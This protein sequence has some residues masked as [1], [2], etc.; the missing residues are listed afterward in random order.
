MTTSRRPL[1]VAFALLAGVAATSL[2][3]CNAGPEDE[4]PPPVEEVRNHRYG[5]VNAVIETTLDRAALTDAQLDVV[6]AIQDEVTAHR[7]ERK[8]L[9]EEMRTAASAIVREG[10]TDSAEFDAMV[11]RAAVAIEKRVEMSADAVKD[12]HELLEPEQRA[13]VAEGLRER[14]DRRWGN[15]H[16]R[17]HEAFDTFA[18]ELA[19]TDDQ[20]RG[21]EKVRDEMLGQ[22]KRLKPTAEELYDLVDAFET[23]DFAAALD[24]FHAERAPLLR[25]KLAT[26]GDHADTILGLLEDGQ[27]DILAQLI[28]EG[29][30]S[31]AERR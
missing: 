9:R 19:L 11:E 17:R 10:T 16:R 21:I 23:E 8:Q 12:L 14:I 4:P 24:A 26:A 13:A 3:A 15:V 5:A 6:L 30:G 31:L 27:R 22:S 25:E 20:I 18:R 7:A 29:P 28:E 1:F 2:P